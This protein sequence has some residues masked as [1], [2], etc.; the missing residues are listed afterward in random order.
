MR[1]LPFQFHLITEPVTREFELRCVPLFC[2][3][4][5][6]RVSRHV[7]FEVSAI[8]VKRQNNSLLQFCVEVADMPLHLVSV[9][10]SAV[11]YRSLETGRG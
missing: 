8:S 11:V 2:D 3:G 10:A 4:L 7:P 6:Q 5:V 9:P 1:V